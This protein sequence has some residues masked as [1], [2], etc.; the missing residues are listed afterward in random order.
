M[1]EWSAIMP[2]SSPYQ[3]Q[4]EGRGLTASALFVPYSLEC[5]EYAFSEVRG[6]KRF[7]VDAE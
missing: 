2:Q 7:R 5:V 1:P 6:S 4:E 3:Q